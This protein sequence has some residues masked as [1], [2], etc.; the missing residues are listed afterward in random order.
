MDGKLIPT[1]A[2][3]HG[4]KINTTAQDRLMMRLFPAVGIALCFFPDLM[5]ATTLLAQ[6]KT[7][8]RWEKDIAAVEERI[9]SGESPQNAV[10][11]VGS[12][13]IRLWKLEESFP[14]LKTANHGFGGSHLAD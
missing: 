9:A 14:D 1:Y 5:S 8:D 7:P 3:R 6:D 10:L 13:S 4:P 2:D 12:S 11:F